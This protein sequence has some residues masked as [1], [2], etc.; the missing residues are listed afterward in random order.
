MI[1]ARTEFREV[2]PDSAWLTEIVDLWAVAFPTVGLASREVRDAYEERTRAR[3][4]AENVRCVAVLHDGHVVGAMLV[5]HFLAN[6]R[7]QDASF[8][9]AGGIAVSP[10]FRG[11]GIG[12]GLVRHLFGLTL[13][14]GG[15]FTSLYPFRYE[16]YRRY[17][18][19]YGTPTQ[20]YRL[21]AAQL[22]P[23]NGESKVRVLRVT[24]VDVLAQH[25]ERMRKAVHGL[26]SRHRNA[27][28]RQL[29]DLSLR[30]VAVDRDGS[31]R[32]S[33]L[34]SA[35]LGEAASINSKA[36]VVRDLLCEDDDAR[37]A[38]FGYLRNQ[39]EQYP[40]VALETQE[41][42]LY[43]ASEDPRDD[44]NETLG[45]RTAHRIA[46][47]GLGIMYRLVDVDAAFSHL[48]NTSQAPITLRL[49]IRA[50]DLHGL[51]DDR[52]YI[53]FPH[54][55]PLRSDLAAADAALSIG[56]HDLGSVLMGSLRIRDL[57]RWQLAS[58]TPTT[59]HARVDA[60]FA[61]ESPP[62]CTA[63]F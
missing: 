33:M 19:G 15:I 5:H 50:A 24:D 44:S 29:S 13:D 58:V 21:S 9:G 51:E 23:Y 63:R 53:F 46:E 27:L 2:G 59:E 54:L 60:L 38:L 41:D 34:T 43:C 47:T 40:R 35:P 11:T 36:L 39:R 18:F 6:F 25:L 1:G 49:Q 45:P 61:C 8:S 37:A 48:S 57:T 62:V 26:Y 12:S 32:A 30:L 31:L 52:T 16:F 7:G 28:S 42:A 14:T 56:L 22:R 55:P 10:E 4:R 17:G 3:L 20:R